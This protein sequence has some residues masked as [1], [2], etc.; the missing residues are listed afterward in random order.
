MYQT[1]SFHL[2]TYVTIIFSIHETC[3]GVE[4]VF[5]D[6]RKKIKTE[7]HNYKYK[8]SLYDHYEEELIFFKS[9]KNN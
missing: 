1:C 3:K 6:K 2:S 8:D 5:V 7:N 9:V 4:G